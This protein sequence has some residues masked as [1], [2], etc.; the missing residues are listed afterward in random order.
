MRYFLT[1]IIF[2]LGS[3]AAW[4]QRPA[5]NNYKTLNSARSRGNL[6]A[7]GQFIQDGV[8]GDS[9]SFNPFARKRESKKDDTPYGLRTWKAD[10]RFGITDSVR[11][12]TFPHF[13]QNTHFTEGIR[14]EYNTLGNMGSP[15]IGRSFTLRP[16]DFSYF[17]F[18]EPY[19]FFITPFSDIHF[20]NTRSPIT[21]IT[22]HESLS[23]QDGDD[24][25][26]AIYAT[27]V[28]KDV[29]MALKLDYLYGRGYYDHQNTSDFNA[30]LYG[31]ILK[32]QYKAHF[33]FYANYLKT[34]ENG[35]ILS[36]DY[37]TNPE[38]FPSKYGTKDIPTKLSRAWNK[39][40]ANGLH[41]THRYSLGFHRPQQVPDSIF[42]KAMSQAGIGADSVRIADSLQQTRMTFVPVTS[43]IHTFRLQ[44]NTRDF[45][46]N[47][48]LTDY[49]SH[50]YLAGDSANDHFS[51]TLVSNLLAVELH[52]GFNKWALAG[53]RLYLQHDYNS[54]DMP[55][56]SRLND[57]FTEN[58]LN[59]GGQLFKA[60]GTHFTYLLGAE[61]SS[62]GKSWGEFHLNGRSR[63]S[64]PLWGDTVSLNLRGDIINRQPTLLYRHFHSKYLWWD[65]DLHKQ[66]TT[67]LGA[68]LHNT[69]TH[70]ALS[71]DIQNVKN[72]T[73]FSTQTSASTNTNGGTTQNTSIQQYSDNIQLLSLSLSQDFK[74]G[75]LNWENQ[76]S[77]QTTSESDII[78]QP[79]FSAYTNLY[80]LF[81][82]AHVLRVELG[83]D[84]RYF[85]SYYAPTYSPAVGMFALQSESDRTKI[86][87]YPIINA[88][89]NF[90]LKHTRFY[91]MASHVN[92]SRDSSG[93]QFLVPHYPV[94]PFLI[95]LGLSW[96]FFN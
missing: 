70:T 67:R 4:S 26:K 76:L 15:R 12:D 88:Y 3:C 91:V 43:F 46:A 50:K 73:Y 53:I 54:Y 2:V 16:L 38:N 1:I 39:I 69:S 21:N 7:S 28:N 5:D 22:Y 32:D 90:H 61:A 71:L 18:T 60:Q 92:Y 25:I 35:G 72:Y 74:F 11:T 85:S 27:N 20:T 45:L 65:N 29:G 13:F 62:T 77:F 19:D 48:S 6:N 41:W 57:E 93:S 33:S 82:I 95:R 59:L 94:N 9:L 80:L 55:S 17:F 8:D 68:T 51:N 58:R 81:H 75:P 30:T 49:Y 83:A 34:G 78:P 10:P 47:E 14:G 84:A 36:D 31:S 52:E 37:I 89:A 63:L 64:V 44:R 79:K 40:H 42:R 96:N 66:F 86:G 23:S 24:R 87:N 56:L